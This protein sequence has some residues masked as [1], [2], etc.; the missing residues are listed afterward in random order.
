MNDQPAW[1]F[2]SLSLLRTSSRRQS[3]EGLAEFPCVRGAL[4]LSGL[5]DWGNHRD[6]LAV[7]GEDS[8][9]A[10]GGGPGELGEA[11][12]GFPNTDRLHSC[13]S[14]HP[15]AR[16]AGSRGVTTFRLD[17]AAGR[18]RVTAWVETFALAD[19]SVTTSW[20]SILSRA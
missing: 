14:T 11:S 7:V 5:L 13:L 1:D 17:R 8:G 6:R 2:P 12:L 20:F 16:I 10:L 15:G 4:F 3:T 9:L 18:P 19:A